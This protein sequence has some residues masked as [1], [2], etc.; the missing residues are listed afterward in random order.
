MASCNQ[1]CTLALSKLGI[2]GGT[3]RPRDADLSLALQT[4]Q[5]LYRSLIDGGALGR[6]R[7]VVMDGDY[8]ARENDRILR[9]SGDIEFPQLVSEEIGFPSCGLYDGSYDY[10]QAT[11]AYCQRPPRNGAFVVV[12]DAVSGNSFEVV[13]DG[14]KGRWITIG[15][16]TL[17]DNTEVRDA[18]GVLLEVRTS[19]APLSSNINGLAALLALQLADHFVATPSPLTVRDANRFESALVQGLGEASRPAIGNYF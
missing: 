15:D 8:T 16:L 1:V 9:R 14:Y 4:L 3:K 7:P 12:N 11:S 17:D 6:P 5:S 18:N 2:A 19:D 10:G 13:Y